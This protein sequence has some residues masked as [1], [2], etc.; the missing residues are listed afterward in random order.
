MDQTKMPLV[1][2]LQEYTLNHKVSMH[3]PGHKDG[4]GAEA[5]FKNFIGENVFKA[6]ITEVHGLDDLHQATG[7]IKNAQQLAAEAWGADETF[8]LVNGT[9]S[10]IIAAL[11]AVA[12]EGDK[13]LIPRNA[14][15][16]V[17]MALIISGA[18][19]VYI[20]PEFDYEH[21]IIGGL[22]LESVEMTFRQNPDAKAIYVINPTYYGVCSDIEKIVDIAHSYGALVIADE[23]HGSHIY[24]NDKLPKGAMACGA[25]AS[26]QSTHKMAGSF[27]QSSMLHVKAGSFDA[28]KLKTNLSMMQSTSP[29]YLL[30]ASLDAARSNMAINGRNILENLIM[31]AEQTQIKLSKMN[32]IECLNKTIIGQ[33]GISDF[34][35]LRFIISA[36]GLGINGYDLYEKLYSDYGIE[37]EFADDL[38]CICVLGPGTQESDFQKILEAASDISE[39]SH[40]SM[41]SVDPPLS[42][43]KTPPALMKPRTAY[44]SKRE[45]V[46]W[47]KSLG[48]I[49]AE[50]IIPYPPGIPVLC[51]GES[52]TTDVWNFLDHYKKD[53]RHLHG[54][55]NGTLDF[56][57]VVV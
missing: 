53:G 51:P 35:P 28:M 3:I 1:E 37:A 16:S 19:P 22:S 30:M 38:H 57:D 9:T 54:P 48:R 49:S 18:I 23:A 45:T 10:G 44:F 55:I 47:E 5:G 41:E 46:P 36:R 34:E 52:I 15:K 29:S 12:N 11:T 4:Q 50:M 25:D 2:A 33:Y 7:V 56:I 31:L 27:T 43:P 14:H 24:F 32:G 26:I 20:Q 6:D 40:S 21:G 8:F 17:N 42:F 39:K 13:I